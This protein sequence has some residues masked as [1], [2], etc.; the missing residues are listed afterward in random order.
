[1]HFR[2]GEQNFA[3]ESLTEATEQLLTKKA[4]LFGEV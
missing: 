3:G 1:M 2:K 4:V